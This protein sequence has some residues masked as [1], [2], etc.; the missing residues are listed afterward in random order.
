MLFTEV[1]YQWRNI[2]KLIQGNYLEKK[3]R[4]SGPL[5]ILYNI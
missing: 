3:I 4:S 5:G 2:Y 1:L